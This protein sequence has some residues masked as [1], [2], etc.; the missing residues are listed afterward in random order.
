MFNTFLKEKIMVNQNI[1]RMT[2][3]VS[4]RADSKITLEIED[5]PVAVRYAAEIQKEVDD[6]LRFV[7]LAVKARPGS[8]YHKTLKNKTWHCYQAIQGWRGSL[9]F[10]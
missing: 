7:R 4:L 2:R 1:V 10:E 8:K 5:N 9:T 6:L 3:T